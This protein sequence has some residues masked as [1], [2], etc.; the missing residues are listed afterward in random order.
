MKMFAGQEKLKLGFPKSVVYEYINQQN[1]LSI[2]H[3]L[4]AAATGL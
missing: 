4:A 2:P 3:P 1:W